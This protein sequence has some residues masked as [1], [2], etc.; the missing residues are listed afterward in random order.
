MDTSNNKG[1]SAL[2]IQRYHA[3][4]MSAAEMHAL[5]KAA[6]NDP[7]LA[8]ALEGYTYTASPDDDLKKIE[9]RLQ[10]KIETQQTTPLFFRH[11][12]WMRVAALFL[13]VAGFSWFIYQNIDSNDNLNVTSQ[14]HFSTKEDSASVTQ[15]L[16]LNNQYEDS[17]NNDVSLQQNTSSN[18]NELK[19]N[20][21]GIEN[22]TNLNEGD[23][24]SSDSK[25]NVNS[26]E[27]N[28]REVWQQQRSKTDNTALNVGAASKRTEE[29]SSYNGAEPPAKKEMASRKD[30]LAFRDVMNGNVAGVKTPDSI[31]NVDVVLKPIPGKVEEVTISAPANKS[32][33][34]FRPTVFV[35]TLEP[36]GGYVKFDEYIANNFKIADELKSK[37]VSGEVQLTFDVNQFGQA[38]NIKVEK[39]M[40]EKCDEEAIRMLKEGPKWKQKKN[41]KGKITI[42]F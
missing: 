23:A 3:G 36:A 38:T 10:K 37:D 24:T 11:T 9:N 18:K 2:D 41:K 7:F 8:D 34:Y 31:K 29:I 19:V 33:A 30:S 15:M 4:Q 39:S 25:V 12:P 5:E 14:E 17:V 21:P 6:Q 26:I 28:K 13:L 27:K 20:A 35:D 32:R 1:F 40:C 16:N 42:R 22:N